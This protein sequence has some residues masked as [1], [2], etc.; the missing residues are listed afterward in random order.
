MICFSRRINEQSNSEF[1]FVC[2]PLFIINT[3]YLYPLF[4]IIPLLDDF[5]FLKSQNKPF[6][7]NET[8]KIP[9]NR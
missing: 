1:G 8:F 7:C 3:S 6:P 4:I 2:D 9:E 5:W